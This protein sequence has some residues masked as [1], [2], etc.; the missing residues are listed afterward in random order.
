MPDVYIDASEVVALAGTLQ[1]AAAT[2]D[3]ES[4][5]SVTLAAQATE[6]QAK[7]LVPVRT[8]DLRDSIH[9]EGSGLEQEVIADSDHA[10]YQEF[11]TSRHGPQPFMYPA[12]DLGE[13]LLEELSETDVDPFGT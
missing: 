7:A 2:I 3:L 6:A 13:R 10:V 5:A 8:G 12:G 11:G 1:L 4:A 9:I